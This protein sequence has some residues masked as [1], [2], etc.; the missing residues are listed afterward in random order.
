MST[1][2]TGQLQVLSMGDSTPQE[3]EVGLETRKSITTR[4]Y[5]PPNPAHRVYTTCSYNRLKRYLVHYKG[6]HKKEAWEICIC[7]AL[8]QK[9]WCPW[10]AT[11]RNPTKFQQPWGCRS[12]R[13]SYLPSESLDG[14]NRPRLPS[15]AS[16]RHPPCHALSV[17]WK[18]K[19]EF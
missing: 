8:L 15:S 3:W 18:L 2:R 1:I 16:A 14:S 5:D 19:P 12:M 7:Y 9:H 17:S 10:L 11:M 4:A 13:F 6:W